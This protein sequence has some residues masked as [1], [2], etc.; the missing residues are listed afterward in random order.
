MGALVLEL[1]CRQWVAWQD[2]DE[3]CIPLVSVNVSVLQLAAPGFVRTVRDVLERTGAAASGLCLEITE[4]ALGSDGGHLVAQL[5][6]LRALGLRISVD[7]FGTGF[8][9]LARLRDFPVDELKI[10]RSF[11]RDMHLHE[12]DRAIVRSIVAL[13]S[14][15]RLTVVA[16]G[17]ET[18]EQLAILR[19]LGCDAAQ[20]HLFSVPAPAAVVQRC[21]RDR[22]S[23][24]RGLSRAPHEGRAPM[25][26]ATDA[27]VGF[28]LALAVSVV[29]SADL[30]SALETIL[31]DVC[32]RLGWD[33]HRRGRPRA[34]T[35]G[36][37]RSGMATVRTSPPSGRPA[38]R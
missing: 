27:E 37:H 3:G 15:L 1:A 12:R 32:T 21:V 29:A 4:S 7:D 25:D 14:A 38:W 30:G 19:T 35:C 9:S 26:E 28:L 17:V 10:D 6:E 34:T 5:H 22:W 8:S 13:G 23:P 2:E 18:S 36:A 20:G 24:R 16:E 31:P 33:S 11:V